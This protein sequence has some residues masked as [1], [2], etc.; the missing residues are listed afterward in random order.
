MLEWVAIYFLLQGFFPTQGLNLHLLHLLINRQILYNQRHLGSPNED[1][2]T[3]NLMSSFHFWVWIIP[4]ICSY[5][6]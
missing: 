3:L 4:T 6:I 1:E 5:Y 2:Y